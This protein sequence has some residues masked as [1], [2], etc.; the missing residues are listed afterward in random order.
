MQNIRCTGVPEHFNLPWKIALE[1]KLFEKAGINLSWEINASGTGS[2]CRALKE[3]EVDLAITLT[4]GAISNI[5]K[6][7]PSKICSF[8]VDSPLNWGV[9]AGGTTTLSKNELVDKAKFA[10]SRYTSGSHLMAFL[11]LKK[12]GS[13]PQNID[14]NIINHLK[15]AA[16]EMQEKP[17]QLFLWEKFTT[18]ALVEK[19]TFKRVDEISTPWPAFVVLASDSILSENA[20]LVKKVLE[21]VQNV[22]KKLTQD[23][24]NTIRLI[25]E[26]HQLTITDAKEWFS[27]L[28]WSENTDIDLSIIDFVTINLYH[29]GLLDLKVPVKELVHQF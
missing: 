4:E 27:V 11:Y 1:Q 16:E 5:A 14:F 17:N 13:L 6:G 26:R 15:G 18:K 24:E 21:I 3:D 19:G 2:M 22:A 29:L 20:D 12:F 28:E 7:N 25:S 9:H 10:I 8:Y 23:L